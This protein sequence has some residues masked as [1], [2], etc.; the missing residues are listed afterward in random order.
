MD[1]VGRAGEFARQAYGPG[2]D[3]AHPIEVAGLVESTGASDELVA[4]ALLHD[5]LEDTTTEA[6][7]VAAEFGPQITALV[8]TLTE[9]ESIR[10][11]R[12]RKADLR[13]R[14]AAAG[15]D[16]AL[17]FVADK[18]SNARRMRRGEKAVKERKVAHYEATLEE[19]R[20]RWPSLPLLGQLERDLL[21]LRREQQIPA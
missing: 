8:C 16:A 15:E 10:N 2:R 20:A 13:A 1:L 11:Y 17:I 12:R 9:D 21:A 14:V 6:S 18:V 3:L 4:A 19:M 7:W 5:V